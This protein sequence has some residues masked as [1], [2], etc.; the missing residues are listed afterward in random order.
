M[1]V[2]VFALYYFVL[3]ICFI[4]FTLIFVNS[5]ANTM[6]PFSFH[7]LFYARHKRKTGHSL[8]QPLEQLPNL[9]EL[10]GGGNP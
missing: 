1:R 7:L 2:Y 6:C 9:L 8:D 10:E 4:G 3:Y 5:F